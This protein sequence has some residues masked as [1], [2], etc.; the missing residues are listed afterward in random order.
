MD[1]VPEDIAAAIVD[2]LNDVIRAEFEEQA[3]TLRLTPL[4]ASFVLDLLDDGARI[5]KDEIRAMG[6]A[7]SG[8]VPIAA[9]EGTIASV[10]EREAS[11]SRALAAQ[12]KTLAEDRQMKAKAEQLMAR[13]AVLVAIQIAFSVV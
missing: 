2:P 4:Q 1:T 11:V 6:P 3:R 5:V 9:A 8:S 7:A 10:I 13:K 12:I